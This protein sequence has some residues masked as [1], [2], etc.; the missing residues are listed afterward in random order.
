MAGNRV[1][2][3]LRNGRL[4]KGTTPDFR[5]AADHFHIQ[6][7]DGSVAVARLGELKAVFFVRDLRGR[8]R[9]DDSTLFDPVR[10]GMGH[11]VRVEFDDGEILVGTTLGYDPSRPAFFLV[12]A[13]P[14]SNNERCYVIRSATRDVRMI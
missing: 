4:L 7:E 2:A 1:V 6:G 11:K 10:P 14:A 13:D 3:H 12:P 5:P 9:P 8:P